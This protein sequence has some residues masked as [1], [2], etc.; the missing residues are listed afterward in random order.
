[1]QPCISPVW[2]TAI[3]MVSLEEAGLDPAHPSL[4]A[5][6]RWLL[7]NQILG[8]GDWQVKNPNAEPGGWAFEFRND[9]YPD[10]DD[11]AFVLDG[12]RPRGRSRADA[13]AKAPFAAA[14]PG[15]LSMQNSDGGW[16]A[17]D[18]E[19]NL[20]FLNTFR[21]RITMP[22]SILRRRTSPRVP[23]NA[24][25]KWAGLP[26]HPVLERARA[27]LRKDQTDG[28]L[29]VR[30]LGRELR[31]RNERRVARARNDRHCPISRLPAR[32]RL[33][34]LGAESRWR[35]RRVDP[36]VLRSVAKR[37]REEHRFAD[38]LGT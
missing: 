29:V 36:F 13:L 14:W 35:I 9:F 6:E 18:H 17:F 25:G 26:T 28:R 2:D 4:I 10:V 8:P 21:S 30:P 7:D 11:T 31:L 34:A 33:A 24:S 23:S 38:R 3:A 12:A 22:C 15:L 1:M 27:F 20:Q 5:A 32:R 16:G 37:K 19:N